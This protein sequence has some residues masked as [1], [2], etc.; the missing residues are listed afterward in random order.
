[1]VMTTG[2]AHAVDDG[3][4]VLDEYRPLFPF[5]T[6]KATCRPVFR[7]QAARDYAC[8]LD[9]DPEVISWQSM[10]YPITDVGAASGRHNVDF[11]VQTTTH[12]VIIDVCCGGHRTPAWLHGTLAECGYRYHAVLPADLNPVRVRNARDLIRYARYEAFLGDRIRVLAA[13]DELGSLSL[14]ECLTAVREGRAMQTIASMIL[15]GH[16]EVD[17]DDSL[18][19]PDTIVRRC[20]E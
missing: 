10:T 9:L 3:V 13:L 19:G 15:H 17:L 5:A 18:L 12:A 7:S 4:R 8:L 16:I 1:M 11:E 14:A 6:L 20:S 2:S